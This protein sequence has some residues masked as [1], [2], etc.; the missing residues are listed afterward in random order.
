MPSITKKFPKIK[1]VLTG[2]GYKKNFPWL[3]NKGVVS[4]KN[5]Y[6]LIYNAGCMCVPLK[7]GSG[8]RIKI[9][10]AL[11]L[12]TIVISSP[13]GIEG[14][15]LNKKNPP[16]IVNDKNKIIKTLIMVFKNFNQLKK[17]SFKNKIFL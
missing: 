10:E 4:K 11:T 8:T 17:K 5:L 2:G 12:G 9:L 15:E 13:K 1:L 16:Y 14:I 7:F 3:I 6:N